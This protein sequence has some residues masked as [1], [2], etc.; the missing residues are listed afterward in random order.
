MQFFQRQLEPQLLSHFFTTHFIAGRREPLKPE[1]LLEL[2]RSDELPQLCDG[3]PNAGLSR[4]SHLKHFRGFSCLQLLL[5]HLDPSAHLPRPHPLS[6]HRLSRHLYHHHRLPR[7]HSHLHHWHGN[8]HLVT[9]IL[10]PLRSFIHQLLPM[11]VD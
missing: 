1:I 2:P 5:T 6:Q 7:G 4:I 8:L 3:W 9:Q 11:L 10:Y